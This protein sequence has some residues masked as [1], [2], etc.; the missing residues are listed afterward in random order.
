MTATP[1]KPR[2]ITRPTVTI[3]CRP[4]VSEQTG[5]PLLIVTWSVKDPDRVGWKMRYQYTNS[6]GHVDETVQ[7]RGSM[8][9]TIKDY[10]ILPG[11]PGPD[12]QAEIVR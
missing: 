7:G 5:D 3:T 8:K 10:G 6:M 9:K 12:C 11:D 1:K 2:T 4:E